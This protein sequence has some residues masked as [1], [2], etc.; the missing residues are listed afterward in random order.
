LPD[1]E[2]FGMDK[3][4]LLDAIGETPATALSVQAR[5]PSSEQGALATIDVLLQVKARL[6]KSSRLG[7]EELGSLSPL[8]CVRSA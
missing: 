4:V 7:F 8:R 5:Q 2:T 6:A 3:Y 1:L